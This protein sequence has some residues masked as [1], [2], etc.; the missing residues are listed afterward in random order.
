M[1]LICRCVAVSPTIIAEPDG[2]IS[3]HGLAMNDSK[4]MINLLGPGYVLVM[5]GVAASV[6]RNSPRVKTAVTTASASSSEARS[7]SESQWRWIAQNAI[8]S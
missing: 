4:L 8:V 6:Q 1:Q 3:L 7:C 5:I 2:G